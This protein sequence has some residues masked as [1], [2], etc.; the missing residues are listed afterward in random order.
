M[1][2][3][4][5]PCREVSSRRRMAVPLDGTP[6]PLDVGGRGVPGGLEQAVVSQPRR[7]RRPVREGFELPWQFLQ[8]PW[9]FWQGAKVIREL[10][11]HGDLTRG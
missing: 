2:R 10:P 11:S 1:P 7:Q 6:P 9:S 5:R 4:R 3:P 8:G